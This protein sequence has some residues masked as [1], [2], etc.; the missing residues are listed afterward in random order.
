MRVAMRRRTGCSGNSYAPA[1]RRLFVAFVAVAYLLVGFAGEV[2]CAEGPLFSSLFF[3]V[4]AAPDEVDEGA[5]KTPTVVDHCYTCAPID[6]PLAIQVFV[7]ASAL[8]GLSFVIYT[9]SIWETR[10]LDPPPPK[11]L[12]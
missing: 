9:F 3:C 11:E 1:W 8:I 7:P 2:S 5:K 6:I 10:V 4:S 12:T